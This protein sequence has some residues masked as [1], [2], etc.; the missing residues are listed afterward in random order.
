LSRRAA[1][2]GAAV[3]LAL[4][5]DAS[6]RVPVHVST[7]VLPDTVL[8]GQTV[9]LRWRAWLPNGSI[10]NFPA[11]PADDS[12]AHWRSW[13]TSTLSATKSGLREH[14]LTAVLQSFALGPVAVPGAPFR[15]RVP[16][17]DVREGRFPTAS[18]V[19][20]STVPPSGPE[21]PLR[22]MKALV[23]PPWWARV[24]WLWIAGA[25]A[26][27]A[28][29]FW[30]FKRWQAAR[31]RRPAK[32]V[33]PEALD[34]PD[35]E[36][37]KRLAA[38]VARGLPEQGKTLEHG[39][40]LADLLRRFVERRYETPRPGYTTSELVR[41]LR[42]RGDLAPDDVTALM[43]ILEACD[44]TKFARRPYD[45]ARAH[46]AET[47]AARL[48]ERWAPPVAAAPPAPKVATR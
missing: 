31:R 43:S 26:L 46:D 27:L 10:V 37:R 3:L 14:R 1:L 34:P 2:A 13:T 23:P 12:T 32:V 39:T 33:G 19:V 21:P 35:V 29:G 25:I 28:L 18:F 7:D 48:I 9:T 36:A 20:G 5:T 15:F 45:A 4:A 47:V 24:P 30:F 17:E 8:V 11:R 38:L 16:G 42:A 41:H 44:L 40:E 22:D 6:A